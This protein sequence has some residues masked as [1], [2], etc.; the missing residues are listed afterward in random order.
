MKGDLDV[1]ARGTESLM[2][3]E[4]LTA[5]Q[6]MQMSANPAAP[7]IKYDYLTRNGGVLGSG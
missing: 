1:F 6:F 5:A 4:M 7:F 2:R 3:N